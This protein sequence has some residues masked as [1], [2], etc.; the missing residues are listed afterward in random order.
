MKFALFN[1]YLNLPG[2]N[3]CWLLFKIKRENASSHVPAGRVRPPN[4]PAGRWVEGRPE[5]ASYWATDQLASYI[6]G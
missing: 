3:Y 4:P 2:N 6:S 1:E 5:R